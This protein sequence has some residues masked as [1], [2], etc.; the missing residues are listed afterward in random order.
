MGLKAAREGRER[1]MRTVFVVDSNSVSCL[2]II[3]ID[4]DSILR[5]LP[6]IYICTHFAKRSKRMQYGE[7][8]SPMSAK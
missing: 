6:R 5:S 2:D 7:K 3:G 8:P 1:A 4:N